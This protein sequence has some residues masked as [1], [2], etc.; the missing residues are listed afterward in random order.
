MKT[1]LKASMF[2][3]LLVLLFSCKEEQPRTNNQPT[4][5]TKDYSR[6]KYGIQP[7]GVLVNW[8][9]YKFTD[10]VGV[11][12]TFKKLDCK[13]MQDTGSVEELLKGMQVNILT[14]SV[15]S[16][17]AIRD[18]KLNTYFFSAF[19]TPKMRGTIINAENY[20]GFLKLKMNNISHRIPYT[21]SVKN[22]TITLFT[23][24]NLLEWQ[25]KMA[26]AK[27]NEQCYD[28]HKGADGISKLWPDVDVEV[29]LPLVHFLEESHL[30]YEGNDLSHFVK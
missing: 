29:K 13:V 22:D 12:G 18:F 28:L 26:L 3:L 10:K 1:I 11:A 30:L 20:E 19:N 16:G 14:T 24:I 5:V 21:Y 8:T 15:T 7:K 6:G 9:A 27:L 2:L 4:M 17:N 23:N 25:G